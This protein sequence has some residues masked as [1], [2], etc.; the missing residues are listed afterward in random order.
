MREELEEKLIAEAEEA[1]RRR[2]EEIDEKLRQWDF[3]NVSAKLTEALVLGAEGLPEPY[4]TRE[5][6]AAAL[7]AARALIAPLGPFRAW[8]IISELSVNKVMPRDKE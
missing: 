8:R 7:M 1:A 3:W 6:V 4:R 2:Q 5:L